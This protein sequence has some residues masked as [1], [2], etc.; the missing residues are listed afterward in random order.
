M[1]LKNFFSL[2]LQK[3]TLSLFL[4]IFAPLPFYVF[5]MAGWAPPILILLVL[6]FL[7]HNSTS[8]LLAIVLGILSFIIHA[9]FAYL[10]SCIIN[11]ILWK[12]VQKKSFQWIIILSLVI[13]L[14]V[15]SFSHIY[16]IA[17]AGGGFQRPNI[18]DLFLKWTK[19]SSF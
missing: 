3:I 19:P 11:W 4:I 10:I 8:A 15:I 13:I 7:V 16:G 12:T 5:L 1:G 18:S 2:N 17:D 14:V 6:L 9:L